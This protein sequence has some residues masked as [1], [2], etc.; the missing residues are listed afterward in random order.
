MF[1]AKVCA[2]TWFVYSGPDGPKLGTINFPGNHRTLNY[3]AVLHDNT[4]LGHF[5]TKDEAATAI[6]KKEVGVIVDWRE[7]VVG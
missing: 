2:T 5:A 7:G 4:D 3:H 1:I 6:V